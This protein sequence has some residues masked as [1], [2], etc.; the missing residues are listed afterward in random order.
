VE[1]TS[2]NTSDTSERVAAAHSGGG[3][4]GSGSAART[5]REPR[6]PRRLC[7]DLAARSEPEG[8][9][10]ALQELVAAARNPSARAVWAG[11]S[12]AAGATGTHRMHKVAVVMVFGLEWRATLSRVVWVG[13]R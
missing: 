13:K 3:G 2:A 4:G 10:F 9:N 6:R 12:A 7:L 1:T 8:A 11:L 5:A